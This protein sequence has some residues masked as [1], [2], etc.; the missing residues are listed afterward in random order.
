[1]GPTSHHILS[2]DA[3]G[4]VSKHDLVGATGNGPMLKVTQHSLPL[5]PALKW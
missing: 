5:S 1:M 2:A 3:I 4:C